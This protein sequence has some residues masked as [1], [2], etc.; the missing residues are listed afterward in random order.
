MPPNTQLNLNLSL[1]ENFCVPLLSLIYPQAQVG[2][3]SV[4]AMKRKTSYLVIVLDSNCS[5][6]LLNFVLCQWQS[7]AFR[8]TAKRR[9]DIRVSVV[10]GVCTGIYPASTKRASSVIPLLRVLSVPV[11]LTITCDCPQPKRSV[12]KVSRAFC[13]VY[14][15]RTMAIGIANQSNLQVIR[16]VE[17]FLRRR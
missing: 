6:K 12:K 13:S 8:C 9:F 14:V 1:T 3:E 17:V 15:A 16:W 2:E 11:P 4:E 5:L 10:E 7:V